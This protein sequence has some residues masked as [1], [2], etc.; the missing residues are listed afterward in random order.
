MASPTSLFKCWRF[1]HRAPT[2]KCMLKS[3]PIWTASPYSSFISLALIKYSDSPN[4]PPPQKKTMRERSLFHY[5]SRL[6]PIIIGR[7]RQELQTASHI[8]CRQEQRDVHVGMLTGLLLLSSVSPLA[9]FRTLY[10]GNCAAHRELGLPTAIN[11]MTT[12]G[13][14]GR[15]QWLRVFTALP[16]DL[17][18]VPRPCLAAHKHLEPEIQCPLLASAGT[19]HM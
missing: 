19:A 13:V 16:E 1:H 11:L 3:Y 12:H 17:E 9:V 15:A 2:S 5:H 6:Q 14:S 10:Q 8:V 7:S 18:L 4:P